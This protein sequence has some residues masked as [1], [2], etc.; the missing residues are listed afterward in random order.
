[1]QDRSTTSLLNVG[2]IACNASYQALLLAATQKN[3][4]RTVEEIKLVY[5]EHENKSLCDKAHTDTYNLMMAKADPGW[6]WC[7]LAARLDH[8]MECIGVKCMDPDKGPVFTIDCN[9]SLL[10]ASDLEH[11][12]KAESKMVEM[13]KK[14]EAEALLQ[15]EQF[16]AL[17]CGLAKLIMIDEAAKTATA[18]SDIKSHAG[19]FKPK[20]DDHE[21]QKSTA[22]ASAGK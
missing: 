21:K 9:R 6:S 14:Q 17:Y 1:M 16:M 7:T 10:D 22:S 2:L 13:L 5:N 19:T 3:I 20:S 11:R 4:N 18:I 8:H 15:S 12:H